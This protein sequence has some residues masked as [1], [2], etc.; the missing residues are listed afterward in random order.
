MESSDPQEMQ[1]M[2]EV[3]QPDLEQQESMFQP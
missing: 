1:I 3:N 2:D